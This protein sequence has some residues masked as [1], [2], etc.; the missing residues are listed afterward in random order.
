LRTDG[1]VALPLRRLREGGLP[2]GAEV[3]RRLHDTID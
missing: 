1:V 2:S 3:L